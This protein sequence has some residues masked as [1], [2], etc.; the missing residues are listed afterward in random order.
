[1][2]VVL[3][4]TAVYVAR[5]LPINKPLCDNRD[6]YESMDKIS[7]WHEGEQEFKTILWHC[8]QWRRVAWNY[9]ADDDT[10]IKVLTTNGLPYIKPSNNSADIRGYVGD[11]FVIIVEAFKMNFVMYDV[12]Y[13]DGVSFVNDGLGDI[14]LGG[15]VATSDLKNIQISQP[16]M[17]NSYKLY[18][19]KPRVEID[20]YFY[21]KSFSKN[22]WFVS[23]LVFFTMSITIWATGRLLKKYKT[24][25]P[26]VSLP[27]CL[28]GAI[29][30]V[31]NQGYDLGFRSY[32]ARIQIYVSLIL[33][34]I[35][36]SAMSAVLYS[37]MAVLQ[38]PWP[39]DSLEDI[40]GTGL[41]VCLR[42]SS[43]IYKSFCH[44]DQDNVLQPMWQNVINTKH[45]IGFENSSN[46]VDIMCNNPVVVLENKVIMSSVF[47][48]KLPCDCAMFRTEYFKL[49]LVIYVRKHLKESPSISKMI[50]KLQGAGILKYL[51]EKWTY[52]HRGGSDPEQWYAVTFKH[53][54]GILV[55][56]FQ[57]VVFSLFVLGIEII[58]KGEIFKYN[59]ITCIE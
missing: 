32:S 34:V 2:K 20:S 38:S 30:G 8:N 12:R 1:M 41:S 3:L 45:C 49:G 29:S 31:L 42:N 39:F 50:I 43:Y 37:K 19:K 40:P 11:I 51:E 14:Y 9:G 16:Y 35:L 18:M 6:L 22:L 33:G 44:P 24:K 57:M 13:T 47:R 28:I 36:Y 52:K 21:I 46:I 48:N 27:I 58:W 10:K 5:A 4:F 53:I 26:C 15:T 17:M 59:E 25:E 23:F 7:V 54:E 55:F 56:Y